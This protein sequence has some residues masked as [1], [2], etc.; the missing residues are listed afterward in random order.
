MLIKYRYCDASQNL[1]IMQMI[2]CPVR[3]RTGT[4]PRCGGS[5]S[6]S[7]SLT[8]FSPAS[9]GSSPFWSQV[10][11]VPVLMRSRYD[12]IPDPQIR[13]LKLAVVLPPAVYL[14]DLLFTCFLWI[15]SI[16]V[17]GNFLCQYSCGAGMIISRIRNSRSK[18]KVQR[19]LKRE[20]ADCPRIMAVISARLCA[21]FLPPDTDQTAFFLPGPLCKYYREY[22][23]EISYRYY[24]YLK[25]ISVMLP[26]PS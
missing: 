5:T 10:F 18:V 7:A 21:F 16:L 14:F 17:T 26:V 15:I 2:W 1:Q 19:R 11:F 23:Y 20:W 12:N 3:G 8:C 13:C 25:Q 4:C 9:S 6:C 22:R 24:R